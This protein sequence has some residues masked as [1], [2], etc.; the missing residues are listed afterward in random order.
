TGGITA[1]SG[2]VAV[3][4]QPG[5]TGEEAAAAGEAHVVTV[6]TDLK[7]PSDAIVGPP[8][9]GIG[10]LIVVESGM[11]RITWVPVA[12]A[13]ERI[14]DEGAQ[15]SERPVT[16]VGPGP[17]TIRVLFTPPAGHELDD[18]LGPS[19]QVTVSTTP[20]SMLTSGAGADTALERTLEL[21]PAYT[22]GGL[23]V[24]ARAA[25]CDADPTIEFPACHMHQQDWACRSGSSRAPPPISICRCS[26]EPVTAAVMLLGY[27]RPPEPRSGVS[28]RSACRAPSSEALTWI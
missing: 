14:I 25:S 15:R 1:L 10:Q 21:D 28:S 16:E 11:H 17:L 7:E 2:V 19:T 22:E 5:G 20:S 4:D 9:D 8:V 23:H 24:G 26:T 3:A 6:A 27:P 18:S 13:A 12:K